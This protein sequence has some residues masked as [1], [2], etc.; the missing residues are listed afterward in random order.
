MT[1]AA[2][3]AAPR[4]LPGPPRPYRFPAFTRARLGNG[5]QVIV[6]PVARLPL[7]T[8]RIVVDAWATLE[9]HARAGLSH[10]TS[11]ALAEGT[12]RAGGA[13]EI[14]LREDASAAS[15]R[16]EVFDLAGRRVARAI[17]A[18]PPGARRARLDASETVS[19][20]AGIYLV[21][22]LP[23]RVAAQRVVVLR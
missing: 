6:A 23:G 13:M 21:R 14:V 4:P 16:I 17:L 12:L 9:E 19:W 18:G 22:A 11:L 2:I 10:L 5:L 3:G 7:T 15:D 8:I 1:E 20:P